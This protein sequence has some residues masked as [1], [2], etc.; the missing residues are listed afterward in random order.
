ML[1]PHLP[2]T[3]D[4]KGPPGEAGSQF[5][6]LYM[7]QSNPPFICKHI[8]KGGHRA[9]VLPLQHVPGS[10]CLERGTRAVSHDGR[11][12]DPAGV[13]ERPKGWE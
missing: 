8:S 4:G 1:L 11:V 6:T 9:H 7:G 12:A 10:C 5:P 2:Q 3:W 13:G